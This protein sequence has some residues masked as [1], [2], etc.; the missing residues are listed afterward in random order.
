M[1]DTF[2][3][4]SLYGRLLG[5]AFY[6]EPQ[7]PQI[8]GILDFFRQPNWIK[9]WEI[10][11]DVKTSEK[12]TALITQGLTQDISEQYQ[13]LFIGPN[14]LPAPPWGSVYLD[15]ESVIFGNS[16]LALRDFLRHHQI[17]FQA[18]QDEPEDHIGLML[19]L[20]A[21]LAENRPHLIAE[22]LRE[23]L[24]IWALHFFK[25]LAKV[26][27]APFYQGIALLTEQTLQQW[28][29]TLHID[30]PKVKFYR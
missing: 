21:Y 5:A 16:Q 2:Q 27:N 7:T 6:Y 30:I 25:Q 8:R 22:F 23:H 3:Q 12:I 9:E 20:A 17:A 19:M 24:L 29:S 28:Q 13:R 26:E 4:I 15:P 10:P 18:Q 14:E 11:L 1:Q